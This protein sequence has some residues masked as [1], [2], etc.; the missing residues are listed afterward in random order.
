M[1]KVV[2]KLSLL[3]KDS[4]QPVRGFEVIA[5]A[6][7]TGGGVQTGDVLF[8]LNPP[9]PG[10]PWVALHN[11]TDD[12]LD[13]PLNQVPAGVNG[14]V[15]LTLRGPISGVAG[16]RITYETYVVL[17]R[18]RDDTV[19]LLFE[20][21][22]D[23][24]ASKPEKAIPETETL[25]PKQADKIEA[26]FAAKEAADAGN[27]SEAAVFEG[28]A[29]DLGV[30]P[31]DVRPDWYG[32]ADLACHKILARI[33]D[34]GV[35]PTPDKTVQLLYPGASYFVTPPQP[36]GRGL[37]NPTELYARARSGRIWMVVRDAANPSDFQ[38]IWVDVSRTP[39][40]EVV[41][42]PGGVQTLPAPKSPVHKTELVRVAL[43]GYDNIVPFT[44]KNDQ[45]TSAAVAAKN[46]QAIDIGHAWLQQEHGNALHKRVLALYDEHKDSYF[47]L[48]S[49]LDYAWGAFA[50]DS[51]T[52]LQGSRIHDERKITHVLVEYVE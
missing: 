29:A 13:I 14:I 49:H 18:K 50:W 28:L 25:D 11:G 17:R 12:P 33:A 36:L 6:W 39:L 51:K 22:P 37:N 5:Q 16:D 32:R 35:P 45:A 15:K 8:P 38:K 52:L 46:E 10:H 48:S 27:K 47:I 34:V 7:G 21:C 1:P 19:T 44:N 26:M 42:V 24:N 41:L 9:D 31:P 20:D 30:I 3:F 2:Y 40:Q 43:S 23:L 4:K